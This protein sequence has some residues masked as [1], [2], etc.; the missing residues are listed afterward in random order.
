MGDNAKYTLAKFAKLYVDYLSPIDSIAST[1]NKQRDYE[2]YLN[3]TKS[4]I[5]YGAVSDKDGI[6]RELES[7]FTSSTQEKL[8]NSILDGMVIKL[9]II[10]QEEY[11][12]KKLDKQSY[13]KI[14]E[15]YLDKNYSAIEKF[16]FIIKKLTKQDNDFIFAKKP[17]LFEEFKIKDT[18]LDDKQVAPLLTKL[19]EFSKLFIQ[20][21]TKEKSLPT[22]NNLKNNLK[23]ELKIN[24]LIVSVEFCNALHHLGLFFRNEN[25][26]ENIKRAKRHLERASL[27]MQ[28]AV[29]LTKDVDIDILTRR[30]N[31]IKNVGSSI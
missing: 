23:N 2:F 31:Q 1:I 18:E 25:I 30:V 3:I 26:E 24:Y 22:K 5:K 15:T 21:S 8:K 12:N 6:L 14:W 9:K 20:M 4:Y 13:Q 16:N 10:S 19:R 17:E 28:R 11:N 29:D 27:D 7:Y